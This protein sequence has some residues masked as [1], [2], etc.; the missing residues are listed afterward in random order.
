MKHFKSPYFFVLCVLLCL[1]FVNS[2]VAIA[3]DGICAST[4]S[5]CDQGEAFTVCKAALEHAIQRIVNYGWTPQVEK[6]CTQNLETHGYTYLCDVRALQRTSIY[7]CF[8]AGTDQR[9]GGFVYNTT[10]NSRPEEFNWGYADRVCYKGCTYAGHRDP[11]DQRVFFATILGTETLGVCTVGPATPEP[12][13]P[14]PPPPD[15]PPD[16][17]PTDPPPDPPPTDPPPCT[18]TN[19]PPPPDPPPTD[20]PPCT[21]SNC[22]PDPPPC[23]GTNCN[24]EP[25]TG[26]NCPPEPCEGEDCNGNGTSSGGGDCSA[27]PV[28]TGDPLLV[29]VIQQQWLE[30]C[31]PSREDSNNDGQPDWTETAPADTPPALPS[32]EGP[33]GVRTLTV[34]PSLLDTSGIIGGGGCPPF[35]AFTF[36]SVTVS[37]DDSIWCVIVSVMRGIVLIMGAYHALQILMGKSQ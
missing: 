26:T 3:G 24:P 12:P 34:S 35:P 5:G 20:P 7:S 28:S 9:Q 27:A 10:C 22:T 31:G 18:G 15:P 37:L 4:S 36:R 16:P 6:G 21:G 30:R 14:E 11:T 2:R 8:I 23:T 29:A 19:C 13:P 25:C 33:T 32:S 17:P 1:L